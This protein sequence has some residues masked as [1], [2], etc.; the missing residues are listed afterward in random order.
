MSAN[1]YHA[2][3]S[4]F[5]Q[6]SFQHEEDDQVSDGEQQNQEQ[7]VYRAPDPP[8]QNPF[9]VPG[10]RDVEPRNQ[11]ETLYLYLHRFV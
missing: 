8:A 1:R 3:H 6:P 7:P 2:R 5:N 4:R 11:S 10:R 9:P